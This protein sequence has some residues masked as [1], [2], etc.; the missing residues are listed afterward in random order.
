MIFY[1]FRSGTSF[2][3]WYIICEGLKE[4]QWGRVSLVLQIEGE[5]PMMTFI[6]DK[7][8]GQLP[9][10]LNAFMYIPNAFMYKVN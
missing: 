4:I 5:V 1:I 6:Y 9:T 10:D 2:K 3:I 7:M 8:C